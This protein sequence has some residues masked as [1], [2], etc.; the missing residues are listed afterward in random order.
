MLELSKE[1]LKEF[2]NYYMEFY[3][4]LKIFKKGKNF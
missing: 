3:R 4:K 1:I 2:E